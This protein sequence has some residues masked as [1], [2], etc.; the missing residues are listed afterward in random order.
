MIGAFFH[1]KRWS[2]WAYGGALFLI[3]LI[4]A[5]VSLSVKLNNWYGE[6]YDLLQKAS[7]HS[8]TEFW[9]GL[10][11]FM[12]IAVPWIFLDTVTWY[13][14]RIYSLRWREAI[15]FNY[16]PRWRNVTEEIEGAS[17]RIQEDTYK[18][19]KIVESLGSQVI[20]A[21][22]TLAAFVPVLWVLSKGVEITFMKNIPGSLVWLA[23]LVSIGGMTV[24][25]F[26]GIKLPGLEYNNQ[27]VEA[28]LRKELV[29]GEDDKVNR[30]SLSTL[31]GLFTGIKFNYQRLFLHYGYFDL[32][33]GMYSQFMVIVPYIVMGPG[34]F[35]GLITLGVLMKVS[36]SFDQVRGSLSLFINNWTVITELRSIWRR[37]HEFETNLKRHEAGV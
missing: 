37:L 19:A 9:S 36:N 16:I 5:K 15:S 6:F 27:K 35:T 31:T 34:L 12:Y 29:Y 1:S 8:V 33:R 3:V 24:S 18:F 28:A 2:R 20:D 23:L 25:W 10:M 22:M 30:A 21:V 13:F 11:R 7:E 4:Y 32:W 17:Q 14:T 26:V